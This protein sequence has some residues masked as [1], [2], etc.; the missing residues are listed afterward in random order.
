MEN[1]FILIKFL[2]NA[3]L[4][5]KLRNKCKK[6][7]FLSKAMRI[8]SDHGTTKMCCCLSTF[9]AWISRRLCSNPNLRSFCPVTKAIQKR[10]TMR[11][12]YWYKLRNWS[13]N[14]SEQFL[15]R[16]Q[17]VNDQKIECNS[18]R[19]ILRIIRRS[20]QAALLFARYNICNFYP[21]RERCY[22]EN[23]RFLIII[24]F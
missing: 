21:A 2:R 8:Q 11:C 15:S 13:K 3:L 23:V 12:K 4:L 7:S 1:N 20:S 10:G 16:D 6:P 24:T 18:G 9:L 17:R 14:L 5:E 19:P 22:I